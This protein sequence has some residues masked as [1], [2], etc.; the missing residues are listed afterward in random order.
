MYTRVI[1]IS[2]LVAL[3]AG[4]T[5]G[6]AASA[7][8][9]SDHHDV[10]VKTIEEG[11]TE[12]RLVSLS[13]RD[14]LLVRTDLDDLRRI[15]TSDLVRIT[16]AAP[17]AKRNQRDIT[18]TLAG[19]DLL[20]GRIVDGDNDALVVE[21]ADLGRIPVPL[22]V[23]VRLDSAASRS[24]AYQEAMVWVNRAGTVEEDCVVLTNGDVVRGFITTIDARDVVIEGPL[25]E[26]RIPHR[27]ALAVRLATPPAAKLDR[28]R[29]IVTLRNSGRM[30]ATDF[31]W[32]QN[33]VETGFRHGQRTRIEAE[34]IAHVDVLGG[35]WEWLAQH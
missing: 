22:D 15:P 7:Q 4:A 34:R 35:R 2:V 16:A 32:S 13:L 9:R 21:T 3:A 18:L 5:R 8:T 30:T 23:I 33:V 11:I 14:G 24:A 17:E 12:G 27:L 29:F 10:I 26:A 19:G 31:E 25:G 28:P 6:R 20:Y 1:R